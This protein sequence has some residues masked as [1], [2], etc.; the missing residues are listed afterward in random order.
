MSELARTISITVAAIIGAAVLW[1]VL[2]ARMSAVEVTEAD[3]TISSIAVL[4]FQAHSTLD[5]V[6]R[7]A[8]M[9]TSKLIESL[10]SIPH[11]KVAS[12]DETRA[13]VGEQR[14]TFGEIGDRLAVSTILE[15]GVQKTQDRVRVAVQLVDAETGA[16]LWAKTY[17]RNVGD[18][19]GIIADIEHSISEFVRD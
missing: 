5:S 2:D 9:I 8:E 7:V 1:L 18:L 17:D 11:L 13:F 4:P 3:V 12:E 6:N 19:D 15:G 14:P 16:H 10:A